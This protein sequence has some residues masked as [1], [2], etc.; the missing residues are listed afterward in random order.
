M[1]AGV[2]LLLRFMLPVCILAGFRLLKSCTSRWSWYLVADIVCNDCHCVIAELPNKNPVQPWSRHILCSHQ[3]ILLWSVHF[4]FAHF[5][6]LNF[7]IHG[8]ISMNIYS[9][10]SGNRN[11]RNWVLDMKSIRRD[12]LPLQHHMVLQTELLLLTR[13]AQTANIW[14]GRSDAY[15]RNFMQLAESWLT[16]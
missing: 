14:N 12:T 15:R 1:H 6:C 7:V 16:E 3:L 8:K 13:S 2:W 9:A 11:T 10:M 5:E 4:F